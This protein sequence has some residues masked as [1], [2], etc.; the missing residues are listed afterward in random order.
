MAVRSRKGKRRR[1]V[2]KRGRARSTGAA[3]PSE[4]IRS[5]YPLFVRSGSDL[6]KISWSKTK[7]AEY[8]HRT[9]WRNAEDVVGALVRVGA[10]GARFTMEDVLPVRRQ[11]SDEEVPAY[12]AYAVLAWLRQEDLVAQYGRRG[13]SI[14]TDDLETAVAQ[15]GAT[16]PNR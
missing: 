7:R 8:E 16:L 1:T 6:V 14:A 2:T 9:P 15:R 3:M 12:Q 10:G 4:A 5:R 11:E 13:Y